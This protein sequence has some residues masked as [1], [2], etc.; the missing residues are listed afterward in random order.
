MAPNLRRERE[1]LRGGATTVAGIDEVGRGSLAGPVSVG[2]VVVVAG[3]PTAP[4]GLNDSKL[5]SP[6]RRKELVPKLHRWAHRW[7]VGSASPE[8][9]DQWGIT[10]GLRIAA[11][12]ALDEI[13]PVDVAILDGGHDWL[14]GNDPQ[15]QLSCGASPAP[16][17]VTTRVKADQSC[18]AVAAASVLAKVTRDRQ[19][20]GLHQSDS[21]YDWA[22][23]KGYASATHTEALRTFG[24]SHHHRRSWRLPGLGESERDSIHN[25]EVGANAPSYSMEVVN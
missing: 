23:N 5:L 13:G 14:N 19:M 3:T 17:R 7:S 24:A 10:A 15:L 4:K 2:V 6:A 25:A 8:E 18:S 1:L 22:A 9:I 20:V 11:L 16:P 21:R 12:R